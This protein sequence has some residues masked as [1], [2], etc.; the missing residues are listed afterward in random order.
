LVFTPDVQVWPGYKLSSS[1]PGQTYYNL[2]VDGGSNVTMTIPYPYVTHGAMPVHVYCADDLDF[3]KN[4]CFLPP[5]AK[6]AYPYQIAMSNWI[7]GT[8][9]TPPVSCSPAA[10]PP[11]LGDD[12][13]PKDAGTC[14]ITVPLP[15]SGTCPGDQYYVNIHLDYGLKGGSTDG[16]DSG[17]AADR[18]DAVNP[19]AWGTYD[20]YVNVA[21]TATPSVV[22]INDCTPYT[23]S[24]D[25]SGQ[26]NTVYSTNV[27]K[28]IAG[29]FNQTTS[30]TTG[31][32][33]SGVTA[34]LKRKA[35]GATVATAVSDGEGYILLNYKHTGKAETFTVTLT[36]PGVGVK[37]QD[38]VLKANGWAEASYDVSTG[39]WLIQVTGK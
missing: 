12:D 7:S 4:G 31:S 20:A 33:L 32:G 8:P 14:S 1:N 15:A 29:V 9:A 22:A 30:S 2:V 21:S 26:S 16:T 38:V 5:T 13:Y 3:D 27:F 28:K 23:F 10:Q 18:Y 17:T 6:A 25:G 36:I 34:T 11:L 19:S 35:T 37:T 24:D 39:T